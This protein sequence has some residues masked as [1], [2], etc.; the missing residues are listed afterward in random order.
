[1][2]CWAALILY[3]VCA[4][5]SVEAEYFES[6]VHDFDLPEQPLT[7]GLV[8]FALQANVAVIAPNALIKNYRTTPLVG[9]FNADKALALLI[10]KAPL[11]ARFDSNAQVF[12]IEA[13]APKILSEF[14]SKIEPEFAQLEEVVVTGRFTSQRYPTIVNSQLRNGVPIFDAARVH[15]LIPQQLMQDVAPNRLLD[16]LTYTSGITP[17]DGFAGSNDDFY[18]RGFPRDALHVNGYKLSDATAMQAVPEHVQQVEILKGPSTLFFGQADAG[19][20]VNAI[21][22]KPMANSQFLGVATLGSEQL[23]KI[24]LDANVASMLRE[25]LDARF[26]YSA[27]TQAKTSIAEDV[28][29]QIFS[30]SLRWRT[31]QN[32]VF[33]VQYEYQNFSQIVDRDYAILKGYENFLAPRT[34]A[35]S[36]QYLRPE[37]SADAHMLQVS[38]NHYISPQWRI[39]GSYSWHDESRYGVRADTHVLNQT[40]VLNPSETLG[41]HDVWINIAGQLSIPILW[42][43]NGL[44]LGSVLRLHDEQAHETGAALAATLN[45]DVDVAGVRHRI[46]LGADVYY[47]DNYQAYTIE[48]KRLN[49]VGALPEEAFLQR[50]QGFTDELLSNSGALGDLSNYS[51]RLVYD[52][53]GLY[54]QV[55]TQW[56]DAWSTSVGLRYSL[57]SGDYQGVER[58]TAEPLKDYSDI[59]LQFGAIYQPVDSASL[60]INYSESVAVN[61]GLSGLGLHAGA[62]EKAVQW[63]AGLKYLLFD[64]GLTATVAFFD[65]Q[66]DNVAHVYRSAETGDAATAFYSQTA[67]GIEADLMWQWSNDT[68][69]L[70]SISWIDPRIVSTEFNNHYPVMAADQTGGLF[71]RRELGAWSLSAGLRYVSERSIDIQNM[72]KLD[73]YS[74]WDGTID[75]RFNWQ[76]LDFKAA[77]LG[78][79]LLAETYDAAAVM[80][81]H[82]HAG[83]GRSVQLNL[84]VMF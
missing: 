63:E 30:P 39:S 35:Q 26:I 16:V 73:A 11:Q 40:S 71:A 27:N 24:S 48:S 2:R 19:G 41:E 51:Q 79:N 10:A 7:Q 70:A 45:G 58:Q 12:I 4:I 18:M 55:Y 59:A 15:Q 76:G 8:E 82:I 81:S 80:G 67:Q 77:L 74:L 52:D 22:K 9:P 62:P 21:K 42:R 50:L 29:R 25:D 36:V 32:T 43:N 6:H 56:H 13:V 54:G 5:N 23:K 65:I 53:I 20:I 34:L 33:D 49:F 28:S 84:S 44:A 78:Q 60:F 61:Y 38:L 64:G 14:P 37:F 17:G 31:A 68:Q 57:F 75:Y 83:P 46:T 66:K 69:L 47:A 3:L 72:Q 1:M